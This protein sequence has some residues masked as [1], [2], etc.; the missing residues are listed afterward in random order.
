MIGDDLVESNYLEDLL[1]VWSKGAEVESA[2]FL[3]EVLP[4]VQ[5][6]AQS[7]GTQIAHT[8]CVYDDITVSARHGASSLDFEHVRV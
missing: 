1:Y 4:E 8:R 2:V 3:L 7:R 5:K 6:Y